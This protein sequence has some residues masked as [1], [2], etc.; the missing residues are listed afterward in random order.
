[1]TDETIAAVATAAGR[2]AVGIVRL[3]GPLAAVIAQALIGRPLTP[4]RA[5]YVRFRDDRG[6]TIDV[7]LAL[8]F[9]APAS[10]TGEDV[11]EL[12]GHGGATV[13]RLLLE[14]C[15]ALGARLADPGEF[16]RRAFLN[17]KLDLAQA[18]AVAD[19]IDAAT[20]A[21]A[22]SAARSLHGEFSHRIE[23]LV[24][25][26]I[27]FRVLAEGT[28]DFP[29][30]E[31]DFLGGKE[32][33]S[34]VSALREALEAVLASSRRGSLLREGAKVALL[35]RPNVGKSSLLNALAGE[36]VAIVTEVP[37]TTRDV[38]RQVIDLAGVP[39][40]ILDTAGLRAT[41]DAVERIGVARTWETAKGAD[42]IVL[43]VEGED[44]RRGDDAAILERLP[45]ETPRVV[46]HNKIDLS[47]EVSRAEWGD[48]G[49]HV[50]VS[51]R[52]GEGIELLR[53]ALAEAIGWRGSEEGVFL[54]RARHIRALEAA[55]GHVVLAGQRTGQLELLAE[56]LRLAQ[57]Q[58]GRI[59]GAYTSDDL[60]GEIFARFCIGK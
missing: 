7:G 48:S 49:L 57:E 58:L 59:T 35:G 43:V 18:E 28:L 16:T 33:A 52:T 10:Y 21:A 19:L 20:A 30:E 1:M 29:E 6:D 34:R 23:A 37:G 54:A 50:W 15:L 12:H 3:S 36:D 39:A 60:L 17:G 45:Q 22:R 40:F 47:H 11:L 27:D 2:A 51:A 5:E 32:A 42:V 38:I 55:L 24:K 26:L 8:Y 56:E 9:V 25:E 41:S 4:R 31:F 13:Q 53:E 46:V 14:R 44:D